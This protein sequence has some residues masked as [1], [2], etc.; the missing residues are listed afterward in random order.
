MSEPTAPQIPLDLTPLADMSFA[1][2]EAGECNH[3][4]YNAVSAWPD[5]PSPLLILCGP[6]GS[7]KTHLGRAWAKAHD[8]RVL[9]GKS[10]TNISE[11]DQSCVFLDHADAAIEADVFTLM[12]KALAGHIPG[13]LLAAR[14]A[15]QF[16]QIDL[17]DL[18][19]RLVN[20]PIA[21]LEEADDLILEAIIRKLFE[22]QG[23]NVKADVVDYLIKHETRSISSLRGLVAGID[24]TARQAKRD[25]TRSFVAAFIKNQRE[26]QSFSLF[27]S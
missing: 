16:W 3:A 25:V 18:R 4:A 5:W 26:P 13:L 15:P 2:F 21:L 7:G 14:E 11:D 8:G 24:L 19:S 10:S 17:P 27:E 20:T 1:S 22:D 6:K 23:R 12:N 9:D